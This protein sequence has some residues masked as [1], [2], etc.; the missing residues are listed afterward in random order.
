MQAVVHATLLRTNSVIT[1]C[2]VPMKFFLF[3]C[4]FGVLF[5]TM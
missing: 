2:L 1:Y 4:A 3:I 5:M